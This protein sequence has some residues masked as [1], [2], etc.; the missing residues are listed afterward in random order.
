MFTYSKFE[1][2]YDID[3]FKIDAPLSEDYRVSAKGEDIPVYSCRISKYSFNTWWPGHQRPLDQSV[4]C[5]YINLVG[6][7]AV[8]LEIEAKKPHSRVM[9]KPY[10]KNVK[11]VEKDGII[12]VELKENGQYVLELDD[13]IGLLYIFYSAPIT[14]PDPESVTYYFGAGIHYPRQINLKSG[15]RVYIDK[16]ALVYGCFLAHGADDVEI[17]GNG[18]LDDSGEERINKHCYED[19]TVGNMKFYDCRGLRILGVGMT[20]SAIWCINLFH[21]FD[22]SVE[23]VKIFGQWRYNTDGIDICNCQNISIKNSFVHSFDDT[24]TI[25]GILRYQDTDNKNIHV[26]G[27]TLWCDWG[28]T[29]E[30]GIETA[31][32][33]YENISFVNCDILRPG[34]IACDIANGY[35]AYVHN[36]RFENIRVEYNSFDAPEQLQESDDMVYTR[37]NEVAIPTLFV[38]HNNRFNGCDTVF[39]KFAGNSIGAKTAWVTDVACKDITVYYDDGVPLTNGKPTIVVTLC[40]NERDGSRFEN[41]S[42]ENIVCNGKKLEKE[43]VIFYISGQNEYSFK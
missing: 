25:K 21:C 2:H 15:D 29:C 40:N 32:V 16:D 17:F 33:E 12:T 42:I 35:T 20:N 7:D 3:I 10:S 43:D 28:K 19:Y 39:E 8:T 24:I 30:I 34:N 14:C 18:I 26:E 5:S 36:I 11:T 1:H 23:D 37:Q 38:V 9:L 22:V 27:C 31:C 6:D 4:P 13:H 41:I